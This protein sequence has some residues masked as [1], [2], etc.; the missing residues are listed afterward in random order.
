VEMNTEANWRIALDARGRDWVEAKLKARTGQ[1]NDVVLD[2]VF[3]EP[4]PTREFCQRWS[5]EQ[6]NRMFHM[7]GHTKAIIIALVVLIAFG[8]KS[9]NSWESR[10]AAQHQ[11]QR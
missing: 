3:E 9:I 11:I 6:D 1:P 7:S 2:I 10:P 5:A 4:H 8:V